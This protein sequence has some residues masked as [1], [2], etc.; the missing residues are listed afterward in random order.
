MRVLSP[1][2]S[3]WVAKDWELP[4]EVCKALAEQVNIQPRNKVSNYAHVLDLK[5]PSDMY[6]KLGQLTKEVQT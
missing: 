6:E 1:A 2:V 4:K 3:F 5:L